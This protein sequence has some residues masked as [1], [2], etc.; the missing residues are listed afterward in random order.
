MKT[1]R[2]QNKETKNCFGI[3]RCYRINEFNF[4]LHGAVV[5]ALRALLHPPRLL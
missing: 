5:S 1:L 3:F 4:T 2:V